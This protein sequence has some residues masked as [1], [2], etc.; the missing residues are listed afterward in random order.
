M[1]LAF[2]E[3]PST[4]L[5]VAG[6][7]VVIQQVEGDVLMPFVQRW[8]VALPPALGVIA[9]VVF[10]LLFGVMGVIFATPLMVVVMI[11]VQKLYV[12]DVLESGSRA[13]A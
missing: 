2:I 12:Q 9:L 6:L 3:G 7:C 10:G 13:V 5:Y 11:L 1:A 4:A 8:A